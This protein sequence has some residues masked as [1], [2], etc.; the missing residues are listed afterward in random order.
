[1]R[2]RNQ[3]INLELRGLSFESEPEFAPFFYESI[4]RVAVLWGHFEFTLDSLLRMAID[5]VEHREGTIAEMQLSFTRKTQRLRELYSSSQTFK[6][7]SEAMNAFTKDADETALERNLI[8]HSNL[9]GWGADALP[10]IH[11]QSYRF[12]GDRVE[13]RS[14]KPTIEDLASL[15]TQIARLR[16]RMMA[17]FISPAV[18]LQRS[19]KTD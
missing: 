15:G 19:R 17:E 11:L 14:T 1:M 6:D 10:H 12:R 13:I 5:I 8:I 7:K 4:G 18:P 3:P 9:E 2:R 16:E